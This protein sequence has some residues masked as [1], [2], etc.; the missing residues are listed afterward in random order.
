MCLSGYLTDV[1]VDV[2]LHGSFEICIN[3]EEN[4]EREIT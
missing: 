3:F 1:H 4:L 2:S